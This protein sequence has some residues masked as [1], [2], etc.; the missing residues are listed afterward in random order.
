MQLGGQEHVQH[1]G[2]GSCI[3][4][5]TVAFRLAPFLRSLFNGLLTESYVVGVIKGSPHL[6]TYAGHV[7]RH[8]PR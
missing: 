1:S 7:D 5:P 4:F 2:R 3:I 6:F 8:W